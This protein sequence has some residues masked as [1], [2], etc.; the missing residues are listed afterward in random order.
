MLLFFICLAAAADADAIAA[1][2]AAFR[3]RLAP[4]DD[5]EDPVPDDDVSA[6]DSATSPATTQTMVHPLK[7]QSCP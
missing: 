6:G 5:A 4:K 3:F 2:G 7:Q 1:E